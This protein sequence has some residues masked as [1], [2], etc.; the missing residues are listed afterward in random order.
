MKKTRNSS[1]VNG[2]QELSFSFQPEGGFVTSPVDAAGGSAGCRLSPQKLAVVPG[3]DS[4]SAEW[5]GL[6]GISQPFCEMGGQRAVGMWVAHRTSG[7]RRGCQPAAECRHQARLHHLPRLPR[8][9]WVLVPPA[10]EEV[11]GTFHLGSFPLD[12]GTSVVAPT[13]ASQSLPP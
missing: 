12:K 5:P 3:F 13:P 2:A 11:Q 9:G 7:C 1:C 6:G 8:V 10:D 4:G